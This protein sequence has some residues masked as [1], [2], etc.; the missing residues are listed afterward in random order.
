MGKH[1]PEELQFMIND[2]ARQKRSVLRLEGKVC[3]I[4]GTTSGI[5]KATAWRFAAGGADLVMVCRNLQKAEQLQA[6]ICSV[7]PINVHVVFAD[8]SDLASVRQAAQEICTAYPKIDVLIHN[9]GTYVK[10]RTFT[11]SGLEWMFCVNHL[12][13][14][15]LNTLLMQNLINAAP[16]RVLY[17]N[18]EGHR[19]SSVDLD[20][21]AW[22]KRNYTALKGY[23]N[24]KTAQLLTVWEFSDLLQPYEV[25]VNA[26]HPGA[27]KSGIGST[28]GWWY[29]WY[30]KH[31]LGLFLKDPAI[32][33]EALYYLASAKELEGRSGVFFNQTIEEKPA[34]HAL[35]RE[36]GKRVYQV[37]RELAGCSSDMGKTV[38]SKTGQF[39]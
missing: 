4:T 35:D 15:L 16:S 26:M 21:L 37:S 31:V 33:A 7:H 28:N 29:N 14:F 11:S 9:I 34:L 17:V 38:F 13:S 10:K 6:E 8:Y 5:G 24:A 39:L 30:A 12:G 18:S 22:E 27:V 1:W 19:F 32:S 25:S 36:Y 23:G 3:V 2:R 20:D